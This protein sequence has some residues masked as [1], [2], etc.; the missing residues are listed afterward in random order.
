PVAVKLAP[1]LTAFAQ[2]AGQLDAGGADGLVLFT[3]FHHVDIDVEELEI[4]RT[5]PLSD[6]S[7]LSLRLRGAAALAGRVKAS[8]AITGGVHTGLDVI[9]ATMAGAHATQMV[10]ALL[11]HGPDHV[12]TVRREIESWMQEHE[13]NS[14][15]EMRG[16][17]S[18]ERIPDPAAY[19]RANFRMALR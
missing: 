9:K 6:S 11:R 1:L 2:F 16:N 5:L 12:G 19:E 17:M 10:S 8:I 18:L 14:L 13:W 3:R 15:A 4:I 7:E